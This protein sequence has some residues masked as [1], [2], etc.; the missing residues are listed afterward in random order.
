MLSSGIG[1]VHRL[2]QGQEGKGRGSHIAHLTQM[3]KK[4]KG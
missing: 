3:C 4:E 1:A 2:L